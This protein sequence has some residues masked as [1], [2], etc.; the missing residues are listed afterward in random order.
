MSRKFS[1]SNTI[2]GFSSALILAI[3]FT[4]GAEKAT[5]ITPQSSSMEYFSE[6]FNCLAQN[7]YFEARSESQL[8]KRAV[9]YVT[10]NRVKSDLYPDS[11]C[12]VVFQGVR[13]SGG[14]VVKDQCHFSWFCD[15][16]EDIINE[17]QAWLEAQKVAFMVLNDYS[18]FP[19]PVEGALMFHAYYVSPD[20]KYDYERVTRID[21]H[22]FYKLK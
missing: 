8:A 19:D 12:D 11:I 5:P 9:G 13:T 2:G 1:L 21:S 15:G 22:I 17:P 7:I 10:L 6:Q 3:M 18:N 14:Q 16:K 4:M 20:W